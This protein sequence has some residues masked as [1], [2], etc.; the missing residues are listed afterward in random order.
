M[1][2]VA[3]PGWRTTVSDVC[4]GA[5]AGLEGLG[6]ALA[7]V[8]PSLSDADEVVFQQPKHSR[9]TARCGQDG[10]SKE[11][12]SRREVRPRPY[13]DK[14]LTKGNSSATVERLMG[15][16]ARGWWQGGGKMLQDGDIREQL[17]A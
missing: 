14:S 9:S 2:S 16:I 7:T 4:F 10:L 6:H 8:A 12:R 11:P 5:Y 3:A 1:H 13:R 15:V 17:R